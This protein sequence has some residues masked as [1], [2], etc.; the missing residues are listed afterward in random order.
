MTDSTSRNIA[1]ID[2]EAVELE[3]K[4]RQAFLA[5]DVDTFGQMMSDRL[6]VNSPINRVHDKATVLDLLQR[7]I[8]AHHSLEQQI[9]AVYREGDLLVVMGSDAV[10]DRADSPVVRRRFTNVW[11]KESERWRLF[12]RQATVLATD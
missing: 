2:V 5:R 9:E 8:I 1:E 10:K 12:A 7:G 3:E 6:L 11:R 4:S